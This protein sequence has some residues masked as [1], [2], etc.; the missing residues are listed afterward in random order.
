MKKIAFVVLL[1]TILI[2]GVYG[3][4]RPDN[5]WM[6]GNWV[7]TDSQDMSYELTLN[8]DGTGRYVDGR[9]GAANITFS[10]IENELILFSSTG[11]ARTGTFLIYRINDQRMVLQISYGRWGAVIVN[12]VKRA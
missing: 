12:F 5:R 10:I 7:G 8:D 4:T 2:S 11:R 3:Q 9:A 1:I 6:L